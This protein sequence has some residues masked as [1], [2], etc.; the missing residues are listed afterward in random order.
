MHHVLRNLSVEDQVESMSRRHMNWPPEA[1]EASRYRGC[2]VALDNC[3]YDGS[4]QPVEGDVVDSD[5]DLAELCGRLHEASRSKCII[6][7]CDDDLLIEPRAS[8][9][10]DAEFDERLFAQ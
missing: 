3:R 6:L 4:H 8:R 1:N 5:E 9:D 7:Y 10:S 2:W